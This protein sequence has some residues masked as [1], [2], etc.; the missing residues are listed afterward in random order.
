MANEVPLFTVTFVAGED[1]SGKQFHGVKLDGSNENEVLAADSANED[2][3]GILQ[4]KPASG[5]EATVMISG[6]S[7]FHANGATSIGEYLT[8]AGSDGDFTSTSYAS[9]SSGNFLLGEVVEATGGAD[10]LGS[11]MLGDSLVK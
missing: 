1:L 2:I 6:R 3:V 9:A 7:K 10:E 11:V 8:V 4:N 5:E